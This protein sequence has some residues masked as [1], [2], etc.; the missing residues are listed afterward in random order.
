MKKTLKW[1]S[2][3]WSSTAWIV[4]YTL[5]I[6]TLQGLSLAPWFIIIWIVHTQVNTLGYQHMEF[7]QYCYGKEPS[8]F[9]DSLYMLCCFSSAAK[10]ILLCIFYCFIVFIAY[11]QHTSTENNSPF[12]CVTSADKDECYTTNIQYSN[13]VPTQYMILD[14]PLVTPTM[15]SLLR[16]A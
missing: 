13:V 1:D 16:C 9:K 10:Y 6:L 12:H 11:T 14:E 3:A 8:D 4:K 15:I 5:W 2:G 7:P